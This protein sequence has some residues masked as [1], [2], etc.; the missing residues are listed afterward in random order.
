MTGED[1]TV[2]TGRRDFMKKAGLAVGLT[3]AAAAAVGRE[4][5]ADVPENSQTSV[6][7]QET[8]HVRKYYELAKF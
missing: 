6:G 4:A 1:K 7:Y 2:V 8:E 5:K 3:G